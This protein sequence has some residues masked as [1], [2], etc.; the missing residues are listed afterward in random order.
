MKN[1]EN[2]VGIFK[3]R[4][5]YNLALKDPKHWEARRFG[6]SEW[7]PYSEWSKW[8]YKKC[9]NKHTQW[10]NATAPR[11]LIMTV[12]EATDWLLK[13][14]WRAVI[15]RDGTILSSHDARFNKLPSEQNAPYTPLIPAVTNATKASDNC[16]LICEVIRTAKRDAWQEGYD[17]RDRREPGGTANNPYHDNYQGLPIRSQ[18]SLEAEIATLGAEL[19]KERYKVRQYAMA[20]DAIDATASQFRNCAKNETSKQ[21]SKS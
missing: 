19:Q 8:C 10:R 16:E 6:E 3:G 21:S 18:V 5:G 17:R 11:F 7:S 12:S 9:K 14:P 20:I 2:T 1:T 13:A 15:G 4:S